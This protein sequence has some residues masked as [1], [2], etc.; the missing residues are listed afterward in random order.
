MTFMKTA[1]HSR[2]QWGVAFKLGLLV[3]LGT[4]V[5]FGAAFVFNFIMQRRAIIGNA[6]SSARNLTM[7]NL[8]QI[9][10][11]L[12]SVQRIPQYLARIMEDREMDRDELFILIRD[13][14]AS[15]PDIVGSAVAFEPGG[16]ER[17]S[18]YFAPYFYREGDE[19][20]QM[21]L[22]SSAYHYFDHDWYLIPKELKRPI[23]TEPYFDEG[24]M[25][26][27]M[28]TYSV[29]FYRKRH[30]SERLQGI[31]TADIGLDWLMK[32]VAQVKVLKTGYA[33]LIS[34]NG[35]FVTHPDKA[36]VMTESVFDQAEMNKDPALRAVGREMVRGKEG[37]V[38]LRSLI[39]GKR[40]WMY[41]AP[42]PSMNWS[43]GV[44]F[45]E[46]EL[47]ADLYALTR[48]LLVIAACGFVGLFFMT[49]VI[50]GRLV[51]PLAGITKMA[52][53]IAEGNLHEAIQDLPAFEQQTARQTTRE[54]HQLSQSF[55]SMARALNSLIL[56]VRKSGIQVTSSATEIAASAKQLE[57]TVAEQAASTDQVTATSRAISGRSRDL[58]KTM[59]DVAALAR[60]NST[61]AENCRG[62]L[63]DMESAMGQ[64]TDATRSISDK[65]SAISEKAGNIGTVV[66]TITKVADQTNLLSLNAAIE[67]EKAGEYGRGFS[68]VAREIRRLA[69]QTAEATT[70]IEQ[71]VKEMRSAVSS[72]VMEMDKFVQQA[73]QGAETVRLIG[74]KM[75]TIVENVQAL[76]PRFEAVS[77]AMDDQNAGAE[78]INEA[79]MQLSQTADQT[80]QSLSEFNKATGQLKDAVQ[81]LQREVSQFKVNG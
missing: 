66:T 27:L 81:D 29:P 78:E 39:P 28:T 40:A 79:M 57:A 71:M 25:N 49:L 30:G 16:F 62:S 46:N 35:V 54:Y 5:I 33:V 67:A 24:A 37:F 69:D 14:V 21:W 61:L 50:M 80:R 74:V 65:L 31:V 19:I 55:I 76:F 32:F 4:S 36:V 56:Q 51:R 23:W 52:G 15:N 6:R 75:G 64:L 73:N 8:N 45:P 59:G 18:I 43:L 68:V 70:D 53:Q 38:M 72:G 47:F 77:R 48:H 63:G 20:K 17:G 58:V 41:Y 2:K 42:I 1:H 12:T 26:M 11:V 22:G 10:S 3:I 44:I 34:Q 9:E 60:D 13:A 7:A